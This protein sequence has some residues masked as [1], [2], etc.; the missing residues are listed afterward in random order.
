MLD[1]AKLVAFGATAHPRDAARFYRDTLGLRL[2]SEDAFA[3]VF[4]ANGMELRLQKVASLT[5]QPFT[6]LGWQVPDLDALLDTLGGRGVRCERFAGLEQD[7]RGIWQAPSGAR[8]VWF[9]D[10]DGNVLSAAQ[11]P[12][13]SR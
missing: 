12:A 8:I 5:A 13:G 10:P 6:M 4:D 1:T 3:L 7:A 2:R 9:K 11:Y